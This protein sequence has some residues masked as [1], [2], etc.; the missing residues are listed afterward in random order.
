MARSPGRLCSRGTPGVR[1]ELLNSRGGSLE[2]RPGGLRNTNLGKHRRAPFTLVSSSPGGRAEAGLAYFTATV[3][4]EE[5]MP[6]RRQATGRTIAR[7]AHPRL[8]LSAAPLRQHLH[9][10]L[11]RPSPRR[12]DLAA[13]GIELG[14]KT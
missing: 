9:A 7:N 2:F 10:S 11:R 13:V 3:A 8:R 6:T 1:D 4:K 12:H 14:P 5:T